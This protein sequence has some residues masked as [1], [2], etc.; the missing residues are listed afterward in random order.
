MLVILFALASLTHA[1]LE[2][3]P[4]P[5]QRGILRDSRGNRFNLQRLQPYTELF[6]ANRFR[7]QGTRMVDTRR[8]KAFRNP[9]YRGRFGS[10]LVQAVTANNGQVTF[11]ELR[12]GNRIETTCVRESIQESGINVTDSFDDAPPLDI[13][14]GDSLVPPTRRLQ[15]EEDHSSEHVDRNLLSTCDV[16]TTVKIGIVYDSEFCGTY[17][18]QNVARHRIMAILASASLH[19]EYDLCVK[20]Q[21]TDIYSPDSIC[22]GASKTFS[23]FSRDQRC[24]RSPNLLTRFTDWMARKRVRYGFDPDALIHMF[25]GFDNGSSLGCAWEGVLCWPRYSYGVEYVTARESIF[26]QGVIVAH[27]IGHN[28]NAPHLGGGGVGEFIMAPRLSQAMDGFSTS[29]QRRIQNYLDS[30]DIQCDGRLRSSSLS[31]CDAVEVTLDVPPATNASAATYCMSNSDIVKAFE[32]QGCDLVNFTAL[33]SCQDDEPTPMN[34]TMAPAPVNLTAETS[35][36]NSTLEGMEPS[37]SSTCVTGEKI[38]EIHGVDS[39]GDSL[40]S[41]VTVLLEETE[42]NGNL[43]DASCDLA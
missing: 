25:S 30:S 40:T 38:L 1:C 28:L 32:E 8:N 19:Y 20:L 35:Y 41:E 4:V 16:F 34:A 39:L 15:V 12:R 22:G 18:R 6:S 17:G 24:S 9:I 14:F 36:S 13:V 2:I 3:I 42:S 29:T 7:P 23:R 31:T 11:A 33:D 5:N 21:L 26:L 37:N 27:E 10:T 43:L